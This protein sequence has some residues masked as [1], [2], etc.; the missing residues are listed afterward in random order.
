MSGKVLFETNFY[1]KFQS[2][3]SDELIDYINNI[4][5]SLINNKI[6]DWG[7]MCSSDK[8]PLKAQEMMNMLSLNIK[9]FSNKLKSKFTYK[10]YDPWLNLYKRKDFQ[11]IHAHHP[12]HL[13]SVFFANDGEGFSKFYFV[14]RH[15]NDVHPKLGNL[16]N[17]KPNNVVEYK[18]GDIL[19]FP[20]YLLHGL[21]SHNSDKIRKT[22]SF[23]F[24]II[25]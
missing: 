11:E 6:F 3:N 9:E 15:S 20:S 25:D 19:F 16:I 23:N 2:P 1:I 14:D 21:S 22:L 12:C 5:M 8:I 10:L 4:D 13:S 7:K 18:R 24:D 17:Y